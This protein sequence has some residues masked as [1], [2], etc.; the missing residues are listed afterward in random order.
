VT[1]CF[2]N[3]DPGGSSLGDAND[4]GAASSIACTTTI[5]KT[6]PADGAVDHYYRDPIV[7]ELSAADSS[8]TVVADIPG[9]TT[10]SEDGQQVHFLPDEPLAPDTAYT[11]SL[12]YCRGSPAI[13]F[14]TSS[15]G[16]PLEPSTDLEGLLFSFSFSDGDYTIGENAGELIGAVLARPLMIQLQGTDGPYLD[17]LAAVGKADVS[18][19]EQD[20]CSRT[21]LI[22]HVSQGELPFIAGGIEDRVFGAH[23]GLLRFES[24]SFTGTIAADGMSLGGVTY[25]AILGVE[26]LVALLPGFGDESAVCL[27]AENLEIPCEPCASDSSRSCIHFAAEHITAGFESGSVVEI[28]AANVHEDCE[29][30]SD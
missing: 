12:D 13:S 1:G 17:V 7:F 28:D 8:A 30:E 4:S 29:P 16:A 5:N 15:Y 6:Q 21:L 2:K 25:D 19:V 10:V 26:E 18:P 27:L 23:G 14:S 11:V 24:F 3:I 22:N 20:T 9:Q